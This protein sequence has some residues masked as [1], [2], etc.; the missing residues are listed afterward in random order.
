MLGITINKQHFSNLYQFIMIL[1]KSKHIKMNGVHFN[2]KQ[3][4]LISIPHSNFNLFRF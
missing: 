4:I 1:E 3:L 2:C